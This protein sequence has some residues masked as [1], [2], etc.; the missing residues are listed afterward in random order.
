MVNKF[1]GSNWVLE[2]IG[3]WLGF[4]L[5]GFGTRVLGRGLEN[6][7]MKNYCFVP[8]HF[9]LNGTYPYKSFVCNHH[10]IATLTFKTVSQ[11]RQIKYYEQGLT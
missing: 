4:G 5:G 3:T 2:L 10:Q 8:K 7:Q 6:N 1:L 9:P 11:E